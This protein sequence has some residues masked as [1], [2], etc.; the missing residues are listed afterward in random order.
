MLSDVGSVV[1]DTFGIRNP[2]IPED[3]DWYGVPLPGMYLLDEEG[4]V[5][6]KHFV[7]DHAVRESV[8]SALQ[9]RFAVDIGQDGLVTAQAQGVTTRAWFTTPTIRRAQMTVLTVELELA[10]GLHVYGRPLPEGYIPVELA[11]DGGEGLAVQQVVYTRAAAADIRLSVIRQASAVTGFGVGDRPP[12]IELPGWQSF[13]QQ[14]GDRVEV[15]SIA[16]DVQSP[17][18]VQPA[19]R[20]AD[21]RFQLALVLLEAER[22]EEALVQLRLAGISTAIFCQRSASA[23]KALQFPQLIAQFPQLIP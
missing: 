2:H 19:E 18:V 6:D 16:Q 4:R 23:I 12:R 22:T 14:F 9:E 13:Y 5:F 11:V 17:N 10:P 20:E 1:I 7:A 8:N 3:H 21:A 15:I